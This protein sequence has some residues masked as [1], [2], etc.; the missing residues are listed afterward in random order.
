MAGR[1]CRGKRRPEGCFTVKEKNSHVFPL[2]FCSSRRC[3]PPPPSLDGVVPVLLP[4]SAS[5]DVS[6]GVLPVL[7][8]DAFLSQHPPLKF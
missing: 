1:G 7:L 2:R 3:W 4:S 5:A 6:D 8:S